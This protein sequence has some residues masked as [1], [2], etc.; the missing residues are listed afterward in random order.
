LFQ[1]YNR[2]SLRN[3]IQNRLAHAPHLQQYPRDHR[4]YAHDQTQ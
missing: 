2:L 1:A 3:L 4:Q